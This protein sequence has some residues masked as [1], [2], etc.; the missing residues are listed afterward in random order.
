MR[1]TKLT[2]EEEQDVKCNVLA[3]IIIVH[4]GAIL[5]NLIFLSSNGLI[6]AGFNLAFVIIWIA[7][8]RNIKKP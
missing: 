2:A 1:F 6:G 7:I 5:A 4:Y 8:I 3:G